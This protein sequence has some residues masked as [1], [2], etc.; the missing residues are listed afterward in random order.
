MFL[1][2]LVDAKNWMHC[3]VCPCQYQRLAILGSQCMESA[4]NR[5]HDWNVKFRISSKIWICVRMMDERKENLWKRKWEITLEYKS[6][7]NW[8][9]FFARK[10]FLHNYLSTYLFSALVQQ[11]APP[12][13]I[14]NLATNSNLHNAYPPF[15]FKCV[16]ISIYGKLFF[17]LME[18]V[19]QTASS[20]Q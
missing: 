5:G 9:W 18:K 2:K 7:Q 19:W 6:F 14:A 12:S 20:S 4:A 8:I 13:L 10:A 15:C 11:V 3:N 1:L 17:N 16:A